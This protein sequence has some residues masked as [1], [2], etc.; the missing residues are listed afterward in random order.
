MVVIDIE[1]PLS[2][3]RWRIKIS[4][5]EKNLHGSSKN[6]MRQKW[7]DIFDY[8]TFRTYLHPSL[9]E[10]VTLPYRAFHRFGQ[11]KFLDGGLILG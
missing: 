11:A 6:L 2:V 7:S 8:R 5:K 9:P 3:I 1:F 4:I 10:I